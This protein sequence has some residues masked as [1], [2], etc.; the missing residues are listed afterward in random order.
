[1][2]LSQRLCKVCGIERTVDFTKPEN[3]VKLFEAI[4]TVETFVYSTGRYYIPYTSGCCQLSC[5]M[6]PYGRYESENSNPIKAFL[7]CVIKCVKKDKGT[8]DYIKRTE[9]KYE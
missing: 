1:M 5:L 8:A 7:A 6:T 3:F 4:T 9:W 2:N